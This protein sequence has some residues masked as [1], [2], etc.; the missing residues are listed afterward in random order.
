MPT[1][2][3]A[4]WSLHRNIAIFFAVLGILVG[5]TWI[6]VK[7]TTDYLLYQDATSTA[8]SWARFLR[9]SVTDL[10]Q[11][12]S[13]EQPSAASMTFLQ[14]ARKSGEVFRYEIFNR[15]GFT[16]LV[17][18]RD[19]I[20]LV[21]V[22]EHNPDA[23]RSIK[24][25]QPIVDVQEGNSGE[26]PA[27]FARAYV[28]VLVDGRPVAV[29]AAYVDETE[30]RQTFYTT[31]IFA[32]I[33]LC[34][35]TGLA[36]AVPAI[37]WHR[38][39]T[40]KQHAD[41]HIR[42][43]AHH[44]SLTGL[45]NR[46]QLLEKL[47][48]ALSV[49]PMQGGRLAVHFLDLDRLKEV[50]DTLGHDAGDFLLRTTAERLR[51]A[52]GVHDIVARLGG[53]EFVVVQSAIRGE[54]EVVDF[55]SRLISAMATPMNFK[56]K[57]FVATASIG[58]AIAPRDGAT[59]GQL[60]GHA[61]LA[62]YQAKSNGRNTFR[63]FDTNMGQLALERV[64]LELELRDALEAGEFEVHYQPIVSIAARRQVG[65]EALVR[66]RHPKLGLI[67]PDRFIPLAEKTGLI[68][69]LGEFVLRQ[70]CMDAVKWPP[71]IKIAVNLSPVQFQQPELTG[72]IAR[73][74]EETKLS[75]ER[76]ELEIT[77]SV[78]LQRSEK[79][80]SALNELRGLGISIALDDFGTGYSS[81]SYLRMFPFN[82]IKIDKS[83]VSGLSQMDVC[84]AIVCAVANLGRS[85]DIITTAE[86]VETEE[87]LELLRAAGC[88]QAQG[89]LFGRPCP[90][91]D[92]DFDKE[93]DWTPAKTGAVLTAQEV[94]LV[95]TSFS[96]V[97][98]IQD[99]VADLFYDRLFAI[100]P[101]LRHL[102]SN[103]LSSQKRKL[104]AL[105]STCV[106]KLLDFPALSPVIKGLGARHVAYGARTEHY[107]IVAE[108]LMWALKQS[109]GDAFT[110][111][112]RDAWVKVYHVVAAT[113]QAGATEAAL[114]RTAS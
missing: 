74:L 27:F 72:N 88:T 111:E 76:L 49:L 56:E 54:D 1:S 55:A 16:Q 101:D 46:V 42:F 79:N 98:P 26:Q 2:P 110:P 43:L 15:E 48:T 106:G 92:L 50:N 53:D 107:A 47:R 61:D 11:I 35:L 84:A 40:E 63:F 6:T 99:S 90:I 91:A 3:T 66:W 95:R 34:L 65:M 51:V 100:A 71:A 4:K 108:A 25:G 94:M 102:F 38:R 31:F 96:L 105:L 28:P 77:E 17:S 32:A 30:L 85:L 59:A 13:G 89:Y 104:M 29:V 36:F 22:S 78:L 52:A 21:D 41:E 39:T 109:L 67:A 93:I 113:M 87:Q 70:A 9:A 57:E 33:S 45:A 83:F 114:L 12:A 20:A 23:V 81:L 82:K 24:S 75:P 62:L 14:S 8:H 37:A 86:G 80:V 97:V 10:A 68:H 44:D 69:H 103:D 58:V 5:G 73:I 19:K 18:E 7:V 64:R 112:I 60:L